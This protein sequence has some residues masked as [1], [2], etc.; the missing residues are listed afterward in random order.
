MSKTFNVTMLDVL[1]GPFEEWLRIHQLELAH[2]PDTDPDDFIVIPNEIAAR[3]HDL[4][5]PADT[6]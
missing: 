6:P 4:I 3:L 5:Y 2:V 1:R